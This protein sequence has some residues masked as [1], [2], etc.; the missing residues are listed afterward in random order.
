MTLAQK[1]SKLP[2]YQAC[3]EA[4]LLCIDIRQSGVN[5]TLWIFADGSKLYSVVSANIT[6]AV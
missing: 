3:R 1:I 5:D 2:F 4:D 6:E